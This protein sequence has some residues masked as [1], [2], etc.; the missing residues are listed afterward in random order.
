MKDRD[1]RNER[2]AKGE[3]P[4]ALVCLEYI[5]K[6]S[7]LIEMAGATPLFG[8]FSSDAVTRLAIERGDRCKVCYNMR[9]IDCEVNVKADN[10]K[11]IN[12]R[13][14]SINR[15]IYT[16]SNNYV[17]SYIDTYEKN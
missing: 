7:W 15:R 9:F 11:F 14:E 12:E 10:S 16:T 17:T 1:L 2:R 13:I 5:I 3:F 8:N 6:I 4:S